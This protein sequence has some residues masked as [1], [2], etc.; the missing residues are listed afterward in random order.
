MHAC[1]HARR[2]APKYVLGKTL[3]AGS[4]GVVRE[5]TELSSGRRYAVKTVGKVPKNK[6]A[7]PYYLRKLR[8][9]VEIM[10]Q[11]GA[12]LNAVNLKVWK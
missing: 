5:A 4:F 2:R 6:M 7:T 3:G 9:E 1:V 10:T 11:L 8:A 12:S